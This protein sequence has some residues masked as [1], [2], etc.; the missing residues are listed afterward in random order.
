MIKGSHH[1]AKT[2]KKNSEAHK[3]IQDGEKNPFF[4]K[5]HTEATKEKIRLSRLG[6]SSWNKG[7]PMSPEA[8]A[9]MIASKK[10]KT[11]WNK[12]IS[13][14]PEARDKNRLA[15]LGKKMK[16]LSEATKERIRLRHK[17]R[18]MSEEWK[19]KNSEAWKRKYREGYIN[20]QWNGGISYGEYST[21]F[22][23]QLKIQIRSRD[24][25]ECQLCGKSEIKNKKQMHVHHID[26]NKKNCSPDNLISLCSSCHS[27]TTIKNTRFYWTQYFR[28]M[29]AFRMLEQPHPQPQSL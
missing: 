20:P 2:R 12:G 11:S 24:N 26:Y 8:K 16:P 27:K 29:M 13:Q 25:F 21:N 4:G 28:T 1:S 9:K 17:G 3:G 7:K 19:Q 6:K 23:D 14:S 10:G 5:K 22:N 18:V 15:H